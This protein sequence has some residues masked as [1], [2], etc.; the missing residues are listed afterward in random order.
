MKLFVTT[1]IL[2]G[3]LQRDRNCKFGF[4]LSFFSLT[5]T[6]FFADLQR[7]GEES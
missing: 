7:T 6:A 1:G 3:L 2:Y 4:P 5:R